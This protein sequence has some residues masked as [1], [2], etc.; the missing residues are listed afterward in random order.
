[1]TY[2]LQEEKKPKLM[3]SQKV[4]ALLKAAPCP[5]QAPEC[6]C[7]VTISIIWIPDAVTTGSTK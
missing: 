6:R 2:S 7:F 5:G 3:A 1:V 4:A